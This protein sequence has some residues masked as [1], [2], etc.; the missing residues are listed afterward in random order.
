MRLPAGASTT[1]TTPRKRSSG[2]EKP[3]EARKDYADLTRSQKQ[4]VSRLY[5]NGKNPDGS[6]IR[7]TGTTPTP[8]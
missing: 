5:N 1:T 2:A 4:S 7:T 8:R 6:L 3:W